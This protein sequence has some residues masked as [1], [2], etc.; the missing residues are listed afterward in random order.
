MCRRQMFTYA[1]ALSQPVPAAMSQVGRRHVRT[2]IKAGAQDVHSKMIGGLALQSLE[3]ARSICPVV[4]YKAIFCSDKN[5]GNFKKRKMYE[6]NSKKRKT[7]SLMEKI[8][9]IT[10]RR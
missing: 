9:Q 3:R 6:Q 7:T 1:A 10:G 5:D 8:L 2:R 4:L